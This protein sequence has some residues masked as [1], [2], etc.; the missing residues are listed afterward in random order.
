M[1][2]YRSFVTFTAE[3]IITW[4]ENATWIDAAENMTVT[5]V[6]ASSHYNRSVNDN[7]IAVQVRYII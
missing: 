2:N 3:H 4:T 6:I 7:D 1:A 5:F